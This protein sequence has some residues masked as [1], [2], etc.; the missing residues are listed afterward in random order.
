MD[1][2]GECQPHQGLTGDPSLVT[3][4]NFT[5]CKMEITAPISKVATRMKG[6]N[7]GEKDLLGIVDISLSALQLGPALYDRVHSKRQHLLGL[8]WCQDPTA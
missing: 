3:Y 5:I 7:M 1:G 6:D 2:R 4:L 8:T